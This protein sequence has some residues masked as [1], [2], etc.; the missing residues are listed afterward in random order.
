M[1][2][3]L[4]LAPQLQAQEAAYFSEQ[5][6]QPARAQAGPQ[7]KDYLV[8][9]RSRVILPGLKKPIVFRTD[10]EEV[11]IQ[12]QRG[13]TGKERGQLTRAGV[14]FYQ[15]ISA[16]TYLAKVKEPA[17]AGL[18]RQPLIR[19]IEPVLAADKL[20][21]GLYTGKPGKHAVNPDGTARVLVRFYEEVKLA[22]ALPP[23]DS[24]LL[25]TIKLRA[26]IVP[27]LLTV[28]L[29]AADSPTMVV[30]LV[31][32]TRPLSASRASP[33]MPHEPPDTPSISR[34]EFAWMLTSPPLPIV[35]AFTTRNW[36]LPPLFVKFRL[37]MK[38]VGAATTRLLIVVQ[39][40]ETD[41]LNSSI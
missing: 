31:A 29:P 11:Y 30:T 41:S 24:S 20:T 28:R 19:G 14:R 16:N 21:E 5:A 39:P 2:S 35:T 27:P 40:G 12:F 25:P 26:S 34:A 33:L 32:T 13:L 1:L 4:G 37:L 17:L 10:R 23:C 15:A 7:Q 22:E 36:T 3:H 9:V 8:D 6:K 18:Q 38:P